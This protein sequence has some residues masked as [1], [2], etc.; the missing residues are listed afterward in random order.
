MKKKKIV[1]ILFRQIKKQKM[2]KRRFSK[3]N[4]FKVLKQVHS[5]IGISKKAMNIMNSFVSDI[6][7]RIA[8]EEAH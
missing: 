7:E 4:I 1:K 2:R 3:R 8:R 5:D 6:F